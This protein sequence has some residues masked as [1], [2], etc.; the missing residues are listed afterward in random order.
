MARNTAVTRAARQ[1][2][3]RV[4][5]PL[6]ARLRPHVR[7]PVLSVIIPVY[8]V[9]DY[10]AECLDSV[11][12]QS[13]ENLEVI[14]VDDGSTDDS[15]AVIERYAHAD[16]RVHAYRQENAGQGAARNL[17]VEHARGEF[18]TFLDADDI[19]PPG[20]YAAM[21]RGLQ[22]SGSDFS[23][24]NVQRIQNG[25]RSKAPWNLA[26]HDRDRIG[27]TIDDYPDILQDVIACNRMLRRD[28]WVEQVGGFRGGI[29]YED[30]VP[31]VQAFTRATRFDILKRVTYLWRIRENQTST[32]Q[33]K[34]ML[35]NLKDRVEVKA[36]AQEVLGREASAEV[37][38]AWLGR[39][40][41]MDLTPFIRHA[42]AADDE[43]RAVLEAAFARH[44]ALASPEAWAHVPVYQKLRAWHASRGLWDQ[45]AD[46]DHYRNRAG[47]PF[48]TRVEDGRLV[49]ELPILDE[50]DPQMPRTLLELSELE[51]RASARL[52]GATWPDDH[53]VALRGWAYVEGLD[54]AST[55]TTELWW[56]RVGGDERVD[57]TG[58]EHV[59]EHRASLTTPH[60]HA[61]YS[62]SGFAADVDV[63]ELVRSGHGTWSLRVRVVVD[64]I[65]RTGGFVESVPGSSATPTNLESRWVGDTLVTPRWDPSLGFVVA[66]QPRAALLVAD[67]LSVTPAGELT[68]RLT[69]PDGTT[70]RVVRARRTGIAGTVRAHTGHVDADGAV[71]FTL[72][73]ADAE[74]G[75]WRLEVSDGDVKTPAV[76]APGTD[77]RGAFDGTAWRGSPALGV[78]GSVPAVR[79]EIENGELSDDHLSLVVSTLGVEGEQLRSAVMRNAQRDVAVESVT[80]VDEGRY[81]LDFPS[82]WADFGGTPMPIPTGFYE[83]VVPGGAGGDTLMAPSGAFGALC[84]LELANG[85]LRARLTASRD[86]VVRVAVNAPLRDTERARVHQTRLR[87]AYETAD[88]EPEDAVLLQCYRGEFATDSQIA[89]HHGLRRSR[90]DLTIYWGTA[91]TSSELPD[92][93]VRL[94]IGST[95]WYEKLASARYL[96]NNIDFDGFFR[97]RPYQRY[98]QT[99]HG[100][101]FKSMGRS[102]WA[103]KGWTEERIAR[104][105]AR[106]NADWDAI[107]VP[108]PFCADLY[109]AEYDYDGEILVSGYPRAD[110]LVSPEAGRIRADVRSRL[111]IS[112]AQRAV[113]YAPTYRDHLTTRTYAA[114]RFDELDLDALASGLGDDAVILLRGHNNN[115]RELDRVRGK[116]RVIDVTDY[117]EINDLTLAADVAVLDYSSL[118]FD[119]ALTGKPM[120]FF[121]PD[122]DDYFGARPPLFDFAPTAPGPLVASTEAVVDALNDLDGVRATYADAIATFNKTYN[123]LHDGRATDRVIEA[124][125]SE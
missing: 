4:P 72:D 36:E 57:V 106:R 93:A 66:V 32:G 11:L 58:L 6:R 102:F 21:V 60:P 101:P 38:A 68:G 3:Q 86:D 30:H 79:V 92:G 85:D 25:R 46:I 124:F 24:G 49:A 120:V 84:P 99:F 45:V 9:E 7:T 77:V 10:L 53:T 34:H 15:P 20:S 87:A 100:Y 119:W 111:G 44:V 12:S 118:R 54:V 5:A 40:L 98:L 123:A 121:V 27:I 78:V 74:P 52:I 96:C 28:F 47:I 90:P 114:K 88:A 115:Q 82:R 117:P 104:E 39:V 105:I 63:A 33:Q 26:I 76:V 67:R 122:L 22:A 35:Q 109:R 125:F 50:L 14:V 91:D 18:I 83:F 48:P 1:V 19:I 56:E 110:A 8:N 107:L 43:Y 116:A 23:L 69:V 51:T 41:A 59:V 13:L 94:L 42:L 2:W 103:G 31:M 71:P 95:E 70:P 97:K 55:P 73:L 81:R 29:A 37:F 112:D 89:L 64:G 16:H 65:E 113:L 75:S 62:R 61:E 80:D 17:G 108:A